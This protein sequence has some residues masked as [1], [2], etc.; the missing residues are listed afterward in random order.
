MFGLLGKRLVCLNGGRL[1]LIGLLGKRLGGLN[2]GSLG[3]FGLLGR[4]LDCLPAKQPATHATPASPEK[5]SSLNEKL[6]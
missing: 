5:A 6:I 1:A 4:R 2:G 3:L